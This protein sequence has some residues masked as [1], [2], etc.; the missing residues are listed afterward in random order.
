MKNFGTCN[1]RPVGIR[2]QLFGVWHGHSHILLLSFGEFFPFWFIMPRK[3]WQP[4]FA[5]VSHK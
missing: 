5:R 1:S 2:L 4:W 3:I